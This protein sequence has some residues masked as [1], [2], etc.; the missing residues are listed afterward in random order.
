MMMSTLLAVERFLNCPFAWKREGKGKEKERGGER[1]EERG[2][3]EW[4]RGGEDM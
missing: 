2:E 4:K 3:K 1:V